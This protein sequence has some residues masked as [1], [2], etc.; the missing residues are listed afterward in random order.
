MLGYF[1]FPA[2]K[3]AISK[4]FCWPDDF[5]KKILFIYFKREEKEKR[6]REKHQCVVASCT[7]P[8][9]DPACNPGMCPDWESNWL[10]FG[11]CTGAQSTEPYQPG[12]GLTIF[13]DVFFLDF[14][15]NTPPLSHHQVSGSPS[16]D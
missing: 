12:C 4:A 1:T 10:P 3:Q 9:G 7:T 6:G 5:F 13:N 16:D 14:E 2:K 15:Y 11:L 8:T